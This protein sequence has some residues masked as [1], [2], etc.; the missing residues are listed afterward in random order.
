[1]NTTHQQTKKDKQDKQPFSVKEKQDEYNGNEEP[2]EER[3]DK[4]VDQQNDDKPEAEPTT[5]SPEPD[6]TEKKIPSLRKGL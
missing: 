6:K 2:V 4:I 1:M 3:S 5:P